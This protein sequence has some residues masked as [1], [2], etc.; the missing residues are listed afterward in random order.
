MYPTPMIKFPHVAFKSLCY[1]LNKDKRNFFS[2]NLKI[3]QCTSIKI[4]LILY[5]FIYK[6]YAFTYVYIKYS[7]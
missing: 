1:F 6:K 2:F 7:I 3:C 4:M 5:D